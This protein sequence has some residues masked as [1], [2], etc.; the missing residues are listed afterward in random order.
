VLGIGHLRRRQQAGLGL[1]VPQPLQTGLP[2]AFKGI[3]ACPG[4]P[5]PCPKG[6]YI[7]R[8]DQFPGRRE[9]L[10]GRFGAART[11]YHPGNTIVR[12]PLVHG[13]QRSIDLL[14]Y[15]RH[16]ISVPGPAPGV[17]NIP[18]HRKACV[19]GS[20]PTRQL[21]PRRGA[22][23]AS[24]RPGFNTSSFRPIMTARLEHGGG[25]RRPGDLRCRD[26]PSPPD[27]PSLPL[28]ALFR[29]TMPLPLSSLMPSACSLMPAASQSPLFCVRCHLVLPSALCLCASV[30]LPPL[31]P[32]KVD[33]HNLMR[34][35]NFR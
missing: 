17:C 15:V 22:I 19:M 11:G 13:G 27:A 1:G 3:R 24:R 26:A 2:D 7:R 12:Q 8:F 34:F 4:L 33:A 18:G 35:M 29:V 6:S 23:I 14:Q 32:D 10:L 28:L 21:L 25:F 16:F 31:R 30:P 9:H 5:N 20:K